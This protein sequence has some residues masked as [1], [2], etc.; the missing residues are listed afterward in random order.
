MWADREHPGPQHHIEK[1]PCCLLVEGVTW[2][3]WL[4]LRVSS[5][6]GREKGSCRRKIID[7]SRSDS[8]GSSRGCTGTPLSPDLV[9]QRSQCRNRTD[10]LYRHC[11]D[12]Y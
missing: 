12:N 6:W 8:Q 11:G 3:A 1:P 9:C 7:S 2:W 5:I 10:L 4:L